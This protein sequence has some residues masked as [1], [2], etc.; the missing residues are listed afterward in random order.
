MDT[1]KQVLAADNESGK[2]TELS[3]EEDKKI[4]QERWLPV[5]Q[6]DVEE[7]CGGEGE[8]KEQKQP[9]KPQAISSGRG[10]SFWGPL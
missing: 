1:K 8:R 4:L 2:F 7:Q 10:I 6:T 9:I 5:Q 3:D